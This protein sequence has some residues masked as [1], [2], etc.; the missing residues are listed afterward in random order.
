MH[1]YGNINI[2]NLKQTIMEKRN[3]LWSVLAYVMAVTFCVGFI[4][5]GG[6]DDG[7]QFH[8]NIH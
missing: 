7:R 3:F 8:N 6:G 5:C 1:V 2:Y 4:G